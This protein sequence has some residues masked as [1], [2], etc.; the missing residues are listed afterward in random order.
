MVCS[1]ESLD[2]ASCKTPV[3]K[4]C[5]SEI[6]QPELLLTF[7]LDS[8]LIQQYLKV[9]N[10][11]TQFIIIQSTEMMP[12]SYPKGLNILISNLSDH[13]DKKIKIPWIQLP[14]FLLIQSDTDIFTESFVSIPKSITQKE[15]LNCPPQTGCLSDILCI[16][17]TSLHFKTK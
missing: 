9:T 6:R 11:K 5:G 7:N 3:Q 17:V 10:T 16:M 14:K 1:R 2:R 8:S 4:A 15:V 12:S 13:S